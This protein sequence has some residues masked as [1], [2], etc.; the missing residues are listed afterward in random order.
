[1]LP[2]IFVSLLILGSLFFNKEGR[3]NLHLEFSL[4][5]FGKAKEPGLEP[6]PVTHFNIIVHRAGVT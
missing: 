5:S 3:R 1:M 4:R 2:R 6:S